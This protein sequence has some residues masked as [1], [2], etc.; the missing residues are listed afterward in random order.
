MLASLRSAMFVKVMMVIVA[1]A[2]VGLIVLEWGAD[3][4]STSQ[5]ATN[6][7]GVINGNEVTYEVFDQQL[8][9]AYRVEKNKGVQDPDLGRLVQQEWDRLITQTIVAEQIENYQI[10][11]S[12]QEIDFFNRNNPPAEIQSIEFFQTEGSFDLSKY[13]MFLDT[14]STYSDP[15]NK[16]IVLYAENRAREQLLS[17]KLQDL[18]A[19]SIK[20]TESEVRRAFDDKKAQV[21]VIYAGIESGRIADSLVTVGD[22][23]LAAYYNSHPQDFNQDNSVRASYVT[24]Q[25]AASGRDEENVKTEIHRVRV[26]IEKGGDFAELAQDYSDDPGSA[27]KGGDLGFFGRGQMV[28]AFED[29]AFA[30]SPGTMSQPFLTQFGWHILKVEDKRGAGDSL[31]VK[32]R[33]ILLK[34]EPGRDTLDSLRVLADDFVESA[35][36][37]GFNAASSEIELQTS[38]TGFITAGSFFPLL[39]NKT[40]GLVNGFWEQKI[41]S[42]S[43]TFESDRGIYV[44]AL[45]DKRPGGTRPLDEVKNQVAGRVRQNLKRE[46]AAQQVQGLL[47]EVRSGKSLKDAAEALGL[48]YA[49]PEPFAKADFVPTVGSRNGFIGEA[50]ELDPGQMSDVV[51]TRNGA[52]VLQVVDQTPAAESDYDLEKAQ[53]ANQLLGTKRNDMITAWFANLRDQADIVDNRHRFYTDF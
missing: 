48:R 14:P 39:G 5:S 13:H 11:A 38:D 50:F 29:T 8:R 3:Y 51:T 1:A 22:D 6:L 12:D 52:Y 46:M 28:K 49:E 25:K 24:F 20:V 15:N 53:L 43:P 32:A 9:G 35:E 18:V 37:N 33:H 26:E 45:T 27:R 23:A 40:S 44:F 42:I 19:G 10:R 34:I 47:G 21:K 4:S 30:L 36:A 41:G 7:V 17:A 16:N 31:Q 2:F